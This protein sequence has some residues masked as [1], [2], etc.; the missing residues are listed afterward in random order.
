[1]RNFL[2][3]LGSISVLPIATIATWCSPMGSSTRLK[4]RRTMAWGLALFC[5][6]LLL[7]SPEHAQSPATLALPST[8]SRPVVDDYFGMKITDPYRWMEAGPT[9][10]KFLAY[11]RTQNDDTRIVLNQLAAPRAKL[12]KRLHELNNAAPTVGGLTRAGRYL[13]YRQTNPD[14]PTGSLMVRDEVGHARTL[15]DPESFSTS[16]SHA[17]MDYFAPSDDGSLVLAGISLGSSENSTIHI[18]E[19][20]TGRALA[21]TITR[22]QYG[23]PSWRPDGKSFYYSRLQQLPAGAPPSAIYE[24][25]KTF[26]HVL[27]EDSE[28]DRPVF[29]PGVSL[30]VS[31]PSA[32]FGGV[33]ATPGCPFVVGWHSAGTT[34][35]PEVYVAPADNAVSEKT[36]WKRIV[37][38]ED[39]VATVKAVEAIHGSTLYLLVQKGTPNREVIAVDLQHPDVTRAPIVVPASDVTLEGIYGGADA[40]YILERNGVGFQLAKMPYAKPGAARVISLPYQGSLFDVDANVTL[41]GVR[42][43]MDSWTTSRRAFSYDPS[44]N[45]VVDMGVIPKYPADF[46]NVKALEVL[47]TSTDGARVPISI[48]SRKDIALDSSHTTVMEAYGAYGISIDPGFQPM[49]LAALERGMVFVFV[50]ARGG[51]EF[52]E[53]WHQAGQKESKQHTIDDD[54]AAARYLIEQGYTSPSHLVVQGTSAGGIAVGGAITQHPELFA[55]AIDNVGVTD[56]LRFQ[57]TQG[58]AANIPE[59][60]DVTHEADF[61]WLYAMSPYHHIV[62]GAKYPAVMGNTGVN[63]PRVPSW[64]VAKFIAAIRAASSS[65]KPALLRVDFDDGHGLDSSRRQFEEGIAD[66]M[67]FILWQTGDPE[68]QPASR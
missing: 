43:L 48:I 41:P 3:V 66:D 2:T 24:N 62:N 44:N 12:L 10:P 19:T 17:A 39:E 47:V 51:G 42:F 7:A 35:S 23:E 63:D 6:F 20:Q 4:A 57:N 65:D 53:R 46:S 5:L 28:K 18:V 67:A 56:A 45:R 26:L 8:D 22:T 16:D 9:D 34:D 52:G 21:D 1:M 36:P 37:S 61:H 30:G 27:G 50:H 14:A 64:M 49:F 33:L 29:G 32:G 40:L 13:F 54:I 15:L 58:G 68:F 31:V 55:A 11:L 60:G 38:A 25:E 59:F